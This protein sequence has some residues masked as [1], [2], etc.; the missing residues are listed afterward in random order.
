VFD[1]PM[2]IDYPRRCERRFPA[3]TWSCCARISA[4]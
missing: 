2:A 4:A 3:T 1:L